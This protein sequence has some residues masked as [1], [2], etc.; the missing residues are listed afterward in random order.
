MELK[1]SLTV[2]PD[3]A[4]NIDQP[5]IPNINDVLVG[6]REDRNDTVPSISISILPSTEREVNNDATTNNWQ[7]GNSIIYQLGNI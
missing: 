7:Q 3:A 1:M 2:S 5:L 6:E 4:D